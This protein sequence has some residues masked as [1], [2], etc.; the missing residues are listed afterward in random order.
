M[1]RRAVDRN[2]EDG[3]AS[4]TTERD[5]EFH[6][7]IAEQIAPT[8]AKR[9]AEV[10]KASAPVREWLLAALD[11][12]P[13]QTILELAAGVGDTGFEAAARIGLGGRL[14]TSDFSPAMLDGARRRAAELDVGNV[15]FRV[16]DAQQIALD[17]D[18][19]DGVVCR[20][21][22]MLMPDPSAAFA[23]TRRVL[24]RG[25]RAAFA[26]WAAME[27][28][29]W[30]AIVGITLGQRG[31]MPPPPTP[32]APGP[33]SLANPE[34]VEDM[35]HAAGFAE[36]RFDE[37]AV[38]FA[39]DGADHYLG[40]IGDTAGPFGLAIQ[41]LGAADRAAVVSDVDDALRRF[42]VDGGGYGVPGVALCAVAS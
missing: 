24:R 11:P 20:Y 8:W 39:I 18:C 38:T 2:E 4:P 37:I 28:N 1:P 3:M 14:I 17:D 42:A 10:E 29:P 34:L 32:A 30:L 19:V 13:G 23:E 31:L 25:G 7:A 35:L 22:Y 12:A 33:F 36:V 27:R 16:L 6:L 40:L 5:H 41:G 15:E 21:A 26:V 9:R